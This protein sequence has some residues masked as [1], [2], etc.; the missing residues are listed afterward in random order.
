MRRSRATAFRDR[1]VRDP[2]RRRRRF[3]TARSLATETS[4]LTVPVTTL[5][6]EPFE[7]L[8]EMPVVVQSVGDDFVA[9]FFDAN[10]GASGDTQQEAVS[11][12][13]SLVMDIFEDLEDEQPERLGPEPSRR[14]AVLR[15]F[16]QRKT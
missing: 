13:K 14:L 11:N 6:P 8:R 16:I 3:G 1:R 7:L 15:A 5:A 2:R 4:P 12:L 9:R 10:I